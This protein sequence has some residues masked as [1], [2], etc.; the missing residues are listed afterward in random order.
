VTTEKNEKAAQRALEK[1]A[2]EAKRALEEAA[3][4]EKAA[5]RAA[6]RAEKAAKQA[7]E[8]EAKTEKRNKSIEIAVQSVLARI[9]DFISP[10]TLDLP[11]PDYR[12]ACEDLLTKQKSSVTTAILFLMF[13]WLQE[14]SWDR[15]S[16]PV[17]IRGKY[18]DKLLSEELTNRNITLH[19]AIK[20][21][22]ENLGWKGNVQEFRLSSDPRFSTFLSIVSSASPE[23]RKKIADFLAY[24]FAESKKEP[25]AL[26]PVGDEVLT[27]ARA[28]NLFYKLIE[29]HS[30]G[31]IQ[32]FVITALL[33]E[34][35][36]RHSVEVRTHHPHAPDTY[37][38]TAGDIE[39]FHEGRLLRA[40][41]VTVRPDWKNRIS[42]FK[43]KMDKFGLKKYTLIASDINN[44]Q[45][46]SVPAKV[47]LALEPYGRDIAVLDILDVVNFLA[48]ELTAIELRAAVNQTFTYL[49]DRKLSGRDD[50]K[51]AYREAVSSWLDGSTVAIATSA[52]TTPEQATNVS[53][54]PQVEPTTTS[55]EESTPKQD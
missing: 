30:E 43:N 47:A 38:E 52:T 55:R 26:P 14:P 9:D 2:K 42:N 35:R 25:S 8:K 29:I 54:T 24:K 40:Y 20:A 13:Y 51:T 6:E 37:D 11:E 39:E 32:Q 27:F 3:K 46:W 44:D 17:G 16:V 48:A 19:G 31:H 5:Q 12:R 36:K 18:G 33:G 10:A 53:E 7:L 34:F 21:F 15:D 28:K 45:E 4:I 22:G 23:Q 1:A 50:F 41:E 49:S